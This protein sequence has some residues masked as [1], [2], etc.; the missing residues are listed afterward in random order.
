LQTTAFINIDG[1]T[2]VIVLNTK[3]IEIEYHLWIAGKAA[4][5]KSLPH[6]ITTLVIDTN[7][8]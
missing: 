6:S 3:E 7:D 1:S 8:I 4:T 5:V 2:V